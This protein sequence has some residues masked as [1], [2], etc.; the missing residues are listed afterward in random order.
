M[1]KILFLLFASFI[2]LV[3]CQKDNIEKEII[4]TWSYKTLEDIYLYLGDEMYSF[5]ES[6][7]ENFSLTQK[8]YNR[9]WSGFKLV[10]KKDNS[11]TFYISGGSVPIKTYE[12][13]ADRLMI[14]LTFLDGNSGIL[15]FKYKLIDSSTM[16]LIWDVETIYN[17]GGSLPSSMLEYDNV[18]IITS[19][20]KT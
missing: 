4:G 16:H 2:L 9:N 20:K 10:L 15:S 12:I 17:M 18:E 19:M 3:S 13:V 6:D 5:K 7:S 14:T 8:E 1:K 11:G